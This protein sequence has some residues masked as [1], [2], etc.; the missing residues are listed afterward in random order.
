M[1]TWLPSF[2]A[3]LTLTL[4]TFTSADFGP[5]NQSTEHNTGLL[6]TFPT[7]TYRSSPLIGPSLNYIQDSLLCHDE[8]YTLLALRGSDVRTPGPMI[9]DSDGHLVWTNIGYGNTHAVGVYEFKGHRYLGFGVEDNGLKG[10]GDGVYY[11]VGFPDN[12]WNG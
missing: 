3:I 9:I 5:R 12:E 2:K 6:G 10:F 7:E 4:A 8:L 1:P 11:L